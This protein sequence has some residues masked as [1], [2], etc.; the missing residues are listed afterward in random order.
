M[1]RTKLLRIQR[2]ST[3]SKTQKLKRHVV[4]ITSCTYCT[5]TKRS[6]HY[7]PQIPYLFY[8]IDLY[9]KGVETLQHAIM[10]D[11][12]VR[13]ARDASTSGRACRPRTLP[14]NRYGTRPGSGP[15]T[16]PACA[17]L[18]GNLGG[19]EIGSVFPTILRRCLPP[20]TLSLT[21]RFLLSTVRIPRYD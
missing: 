7:Q 16:R 3:F 4:Q 13:R 11:S 8:T 17:R 2:D 14:R 1:L 10:S 5:V 21:L 19:L 18:T 15:T 9:C 6:E 12:E 20:P